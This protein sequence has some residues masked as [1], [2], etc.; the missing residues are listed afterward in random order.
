MN[1][2]NEAPRNLFA[3]WDKAI[4]GMVHLLPLPG[5][6]GYGG[7]GISAITERAIAEARVLA[8][9]G[10]D[11][12]LIQNSGDEPCTLHGGPETI[13]YMSVIGARIQQSVRCAVGVN[14]LAN[15]AV[16]ALAVAHAIDAQF[17]RIKVYCGAVVSTGG[18]IAGAAT[19]ALTFRR[20]VGAKHVAI[21]ADIYDRTS[22]PLGALP[23]AAMADLAHRHGHADALIA[24][25]HSVEDSLAR[26]REIKA[27]IPQA[28]VLAGG[29]TT[30]NN[31]GSFLAE[32]DGVV[33]GSSVK[34]SGHFVGTVDRARLDAYMQA[35]ARA[36][37]K[38]RNRQ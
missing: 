23:I 28:V 12:L 20:A 2:D 29:G 10:V 34:D 13:A 6:D 30:Q 8:D 18:I 33:V 15:G 9:G 11:A 27:A 22:A 4:I 1:R 38:L 21:A 35:V 37:A 25:G 36:R 5:S 19:Q 32:C 17:V 16:E 31:V 24:T 7:T 14:I 26:I 3:T